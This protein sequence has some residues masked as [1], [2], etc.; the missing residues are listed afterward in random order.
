MHGQVLREDYP[1]HVPT[2]DARLVASRWFD[3]C[4]Y[5]LKV[6]R[7]DETML[8]VEFPRHRPAGDSVPTCPATCG[9]RGIG[10]P[11]RD[12]LELTGARVVLAEGCSGAERAVGAW[13]GAR[14]RRAAPTAALA[15]ELGPGG[16][17]RVGGRRRRLPR[18]QHR[19]RRADRHAARHP[20][21]V[22]ARAYGIHE[23]P[24]TR[25][26]AGTAA[27]AAPSRHRPAT[28]IPGLTSG[29]AVATNL[30]SPRHPG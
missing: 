10:L 8:D 21:Q 30:D 18:G 28:E 15:D 26:T 29:Q 2:D 1:A 22:L 4:E 12:L 6:H 19:G 5:L 9:P 14:R 3:A 27:M 20:L 25:G 11:G 24:W 13:R 17:D 7:G 23:E 16:R